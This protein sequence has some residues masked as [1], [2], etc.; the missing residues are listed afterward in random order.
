MNSNLFA[1]PIKQIIYSNEY[2]F[3]NSHTIYFS[4]DNKALLN[5][6]VSLMHKLDPLD[7]ETKKELMHLTKIAKP[8][9]T[10]DVYTLLNSGNFDG[11]LALAQ[12]SDN[13]EILWTLGHSCETIYPNDLQKAIDCFQAIPESNKYYEDANEKILDLLMR[14]EVKNLD[15]NTKLEILETKFTCALNGGK[16]SASLAAQLF[17]E[18][19]GYTD[20]QPKV[21]D[22]KG[23]AVT[24]VTLARQIRQLVKN[25][26][27]LLLQLKLAQKSEQGSE[28]KLFGNK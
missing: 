13:P 21:T 19:C 14:F 8:I 3:N 9:S 24:L 16:K 23:D 2:E 26:N 6:F 25:N 12:E 4:S 27:E 15:E 17:H 18:L 11:A 22:L 5:E 28:P 1:P 10:K 20:I 7:E